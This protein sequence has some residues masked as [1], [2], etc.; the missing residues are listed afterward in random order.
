MQESLSEA[1]TFRKVSL[2]KPV[3]VWIEVLLQMR[4]LSGSRGEQQPLPMLQLDPA[5]KVE[6]EKIQKTNVS[7]DPEHCL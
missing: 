2:S 6:K 3:P 7:N 1:D 5:K 4:G